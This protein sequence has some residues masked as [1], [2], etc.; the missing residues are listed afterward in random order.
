VLDVAC[1]TAR[2]TESLLAL[3]PPRPG[4]DRRRLRGDGDARPCTA[5]RPRAD[6]APGRAGPRTAGPVDVIVSAAAL[7]WVTDHD[8]L[9][10]RLARALRP[11]GILEVQCSGAGNIDRVCEVIETVARDAF[12][13][14]AGGPPSVSQAR[15]RR[16]GAQARPASARSGAG[17]KTGAPTRGRR[18][19]S[20]HLDHGSPSRPL[21]RGRSANREQ[22]EMP[23][24]WFPRLP[25]RHPGRSM[26]R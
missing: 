8:R 16:S 20:P 23:G 26:P 7:H 15:N 24:D 3:M 22:E 12:P 25:E 9:W 13:E 6:V 5:G 18:H 14:L 4:A 10:R 21:A 17:C 1:G 11:G 2:L 19:V